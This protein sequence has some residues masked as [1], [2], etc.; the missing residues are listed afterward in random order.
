MKRS[1]LLLILTLMLMCGL[2]ACAGKEE[3]AEEAVEATPTPEPTATPTPIPTPTPVPKPN[4]EPDL[5][6]IRAICELATLKCKYHNVAK[7]VQEPG[8][9]LSHIGEKQRKF[10]ME[11]DG[12]VTISYPLDK[13]SMK[14]E[15][16]EIHIVLPQPDVSCRLLSDS[17][18]EGA[19]IAEPDNPVQT[20]PISAEK[21]NMAV[22]DAVDGMKKDVMNNSSLIL[23]AENQAKMLIEN[24]I[25]QIGKL[26]DVDYRII[27]D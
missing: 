18:V 25:R 6:R 26:T 9:G 15:G 23:S 16:S 20:N 21:E 5:S 2:C 11:F 24:Y 19:R 13:I 17:L 3:A 7:G 22:N 8:T 14:Q 27:W 12:E 1:L 10:W 4:V